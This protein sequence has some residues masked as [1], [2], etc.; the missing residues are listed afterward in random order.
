[1]IHKLK[2]PAAL[3]RPVIWIQ[4]T[5]IWV[6][7]I[8]GL[9][10]GCNHSDSRQVGNHVQVMEVTQR[11]AVITWQTDKPSKG[12][13]FYRAASGTGKTETALETLAAA[14]RHRVRLVNLEPG[15]RYTYWIDDPDNRFQFQTQPLA[16]HPFSFMLV[17][18]VNPKGIENQVMGELPDFILDTGTPEPE[19]DSAYRRISAYIP[20]YTPS[21]PLPEFGAGPMPV[22]RQSW[23]LQWG[24]F[25]LAVLEHLDQIRNISFPA[26]SGIRGIVV[27][28]KSPSQDK[29]TFDEFKQDSLA[30]DLTAVLKSLN[31]SFII[32]PA[33]NFQHHQAGELSVV[34]LP[35]AAPQDHDMF[36]RVDVDAQSAHAV[37]LKRGQRYALKQAPLKEKITCDDCRKLADKGAYQA[38]IKAYQ[39]FIENNQGHFQIDDAYFAIA[40][41]FDEKLFDFKPAIQWYQRLVNEYASSSFAPL[42]RQRITY[43]QKR[44][45]HDFE[46]LA[47]FERIRKTDYA[48]KK[49][50]PAERMRLLKE[51][52]DIVEAFPKAHVASQIQY[53]LGIQYRD[54]NLDRS[55]Q[56]FQRLLNNYPNAPE[57]R[58]AIIDIGDTYY[59]EGMYRKAREIYRQALEMAGTSSRTLESQIRRCSRNLLRQ[60]LAIAAVIILLGLS[61]GAVFTKPVGFPIQMVKQGI[62]AWVGLASVLLMAS[63][64]IHEQFLSVREMTG[65]VSGLTTAA[66]WAGLAGNILARKIRI[67]PHIMWTG[68]AVGLLLFICG[69]YLSIFWI[70]IHYLIIF[71]L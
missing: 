8:T 52:Q 64:I 19:R 42:A 53:W 62:L 68:A 11:Q 4:Y 67:V 38:A 16:T 25:Q 10:A 24:G 28:N 58:H 26:A 13:V 29:K 6:L 15:T 7:A 18:A 61:A 49:D 30:A 45:D 47:R 35:F 14:Y 63:W 69:A 59:Q 71:K 54:I 57:A 23:F 60:H 20:V 1:M 22:D 37:D 66:V 70:N 46:P 41:L 43:L 39:S 65:L 12:R 27:H 34:G 3:K 33:K 44:S 48:R 56:S 5:A 50:Q 17:S 21:G 55:I 9:L 2:R 31:I 51:V 36:I 32:G 40:L